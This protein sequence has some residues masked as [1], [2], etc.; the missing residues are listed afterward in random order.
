M[1]SATLGSTSIFA[2]KTSLN[3]PKK[4]ECSRTA[5]VKS[6]FPRIRGGGG[7][8]RVLVL[9]VDGTLYGPESG[10]EQQIVKNIHDYCAK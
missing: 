6:D 8:E 5:Q 2:E 4:A 9:D 1:V 7:G 10:I 3:S